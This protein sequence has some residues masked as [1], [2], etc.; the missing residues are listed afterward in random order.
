L[1]L[2][3]SLQLGLAV[4]FPA[5]AGTTYSPVANIIDLANNGG[6]SV[7]QAK[8]FQLYDDSAPYLVIRV[9]TAFAG[10]TSLQ[11]NLITS[12]APWTDTAGTG[13]AGVAI[14]A[15]S[16]AIALAALTA[17][18]NVWTI[19]MPPKVPG[20]YLGL[21]IVAVGTFTAGSWDANFTPDVPVGSFS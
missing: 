16:G 20:R 15:S 4:A 19:K 9:G 5:A 6:P 12:T 1:I 10:G 18:T 7:L 8:G 13:A 2:D 17:N 21:Q 14:A 3:K 11:F